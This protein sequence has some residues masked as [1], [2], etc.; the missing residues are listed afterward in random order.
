MKE[1]LVSR[2]ENTRSWYGVSIMDNG[3]EYHIYLI[4]RDWKSVSGFFKEFNS[5]APY[6]FG[7][8]AL[9]NKDGTHDFVI[10]DMNDHYYLL[11]TLKTKENYPPILWIDK[12]DKPFECHPAIKEE[13][14]NIKAVQDFITPDLVKR[15]KREEYIQPQMPSDMMN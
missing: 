11:E 10:D 4:F 7:F 5:R 8:I 13:D 14:G 6:G 9:E 3:S 1:D 12:A 2:T 15:M